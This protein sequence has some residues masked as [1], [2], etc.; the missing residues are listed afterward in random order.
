VLYDLLDAKKAANA[1]SKVSLLYTLVRN[2]YTH[3]LN[4]TTK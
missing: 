1:A 2:F 3:G 4:G